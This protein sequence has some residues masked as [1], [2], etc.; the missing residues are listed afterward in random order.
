M[1][2]KF[3][4]NKIYFSSTKDS[5]YYTKI[6]SIHNGVALV[7]DFTLSSEERFFR[8]GEAKIITIPTGECQVLKYNYMLF[9]SK[10]VI[11]ESL[12]DILD[13]DVQ[14]KINILRKHFHWLDDEGFNEL[15]LNSD[16]Y[17]TDRA[18]W[19]NNNTLNRLKLMKNRIG[20]YP[21][22]IEKP[23]TT[24]WYELDERRKRI[25]SNKNIFF[26]FIISTALVV[27]VALGMGFMN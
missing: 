15:L 14:D 24:S 17:M 6:E 7:Q 5:V 1:T 25:E 8:L 20:R 10:N 13:G 3:D 27:L 18:L 19:N 4:S 26:Y 9:Y 11:D 23:K 2:V 12:I 21:T 22:K 16:G